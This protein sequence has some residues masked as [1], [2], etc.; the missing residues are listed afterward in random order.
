MIDFHEYHDLLVEHISLSP[1]AFVLKFASR[2][3][4]PVQDLA[5]QLNGL[6]KAQHKLPTWFG[7]PGI[8]YPPKLNLEQCSSEI[9]AK[10]KAQLFKG[11]KSTDLTGGFGVDSFFLAKQF[12]LHFYVEL[13]QELAETASHNFRSLSQSIQVVN[14]NG[15][16]WLKSQPA[17][18]DLVFLDPS[19]RTEKGKVISLDEYEPNV[20]EHLSL[21]FEK[22]ENV[23]VKAS[24]M[25]DI[26][27]AL[28]QLKQVAEA[29]V[30]S[31]K[32]DCK[33]LLFWMKRDFTQK[34]LIKTFNYLTEDDVERFDFD[35][36][37]ERTA[38]SRIG[39]V[40]RYIYEPNVAILKA[41]AFGKIGIDFGLSKLHVNTHLYT[42]NSLVDGFPGRVFRVL[43]TT[44]SHVNV[45]TRNHPMTEKQLRKKY[46]LKSGDQGSFLLA[47]TDVEKPKVVFAERIK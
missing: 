14:G 43:D 21:L 33:E 31:V 17:D 4:L 44:L 47:F 42:G 6:Q 29:H 41:G 10:H 39:K 22:A 7:N 9:T 32:N 38:Q 19:R 34:P 1:A 8:V 3:D 27:L 12:S 40:E 20:V 45:L 36:E 15:L 16:E 13:N 26:Q 5:R 35:L 18:F 28:K 37:A 23:L 24:P 11:K 46:K 30:V 2:K 25:L